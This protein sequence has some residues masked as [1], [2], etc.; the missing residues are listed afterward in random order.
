MTPRVAY[1]HL[2]KSRH[3]LWNLAAGSQARNT[4]L[5][6]KQIMYSTPGGIKRSTPMN[7][8]KRQNEI[9]VSER[10]FTCFIRRVFHVYFNMKK[11]YEPYSVVT[12]ASLATFCSSSESRN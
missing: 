7:L 6:V 9:V 1:R 10:P 8:F 5:L 11:L 3:C 12:P 4:K 2:R